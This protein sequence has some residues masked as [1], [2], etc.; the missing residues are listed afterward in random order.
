ME[1]ELWWKNSW[2]NAP[3]AYVFKDK[4]INEKINKLKKKPKTNEPNKSP[5][6]V[7]IVNNN[8]KQL[9]NEVILCH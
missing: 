3:C 9:Q 5:K 2:W 1:L 7:E 8:D 6:Y 4:K